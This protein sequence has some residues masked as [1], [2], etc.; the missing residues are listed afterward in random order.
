MPNPTAGDVVL[1]LDEL[2]CH[3]T[4]AD[5]DHIRAMTP[6][7][8]LDQ[9]DA[10]VNEMARNLQAGEQAGLFAAVANLPTDQ[11]PAWVRLGALDAM[12]RWWGGKHSTCMH[13]PHPMRPQPIVS[14]AW[15]PG[16]IVCAACQHLLRVPE[17]SVA[18][19]TCDGCGKVVA[20]VDSGDPMYPF[21][22]VCGVLSH[23]VGVCQACRYWEMP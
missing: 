19:R 5:V 8:L 2:L 21:T 17:G 9:G 14:A 3:L 16:L 12:V 4:P 22:V 18:D 11:H 10:A 13:G 7:W 6:A 20:G 15:K 1:A 23:R